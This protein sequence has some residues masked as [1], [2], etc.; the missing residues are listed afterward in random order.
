MNLAERFISR[1]AAV[2]ELRQRLVRESFPRITVFIIVSVAG[3]CA[4]LFSVLTL[5]AGLTSMAARYG[6]AALAGYLTFVLL[7][8]A[9]IALK[10]GSLDLDLDVPDLGGSSRR[11]PEAPRLFSGGGSGG[12][13]SS[14]VWEGTAVEATAPPVPV[15]PRAA[16]SSSRGGSSVFDSFD[17]DKLWLVILAAALAAA[18]LVAVVFVVYSA[19][20]LLAEVAL[21][22]GVMSTVYHR[23]RRQ[24][25]GH[26]T[27]A[28]LRRTWL[29]ALVVVSFMAGAGYLLQLAVP[30]ARSIGGVL[31]GLGL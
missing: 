1:S 27:G 19:P 29:P 31:R 17:L 23:L 14:S 18:S 15:A 11:A 21:D 13:G 6:L 9:W 24:D 2:D 10:R 3:G 30:E 16:L 12:G 8:R 7:I 20:L 28:V 26:W 5:S 22:A 4:F 25:L